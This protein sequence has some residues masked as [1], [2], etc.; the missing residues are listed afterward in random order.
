MASGV[1]TFIPPPPVPDCRGGA[2]CLVRGGRRAVALS[3]CVLPHAC[4]RARRMC[5]AA[6]AQ[7]RAA[8]ARAAAARL[9]GGRGVSVR[10]SSGARRRQRGAAQRLASP[11]ARHAFTR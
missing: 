2:S 8:P 10:L 11:R 7:L 6:H 9:L 3:R 1:D 5:R 4:E